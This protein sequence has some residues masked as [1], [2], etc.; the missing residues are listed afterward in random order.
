ML[1]DAEQNLDNVENYS[2]SKLT[3]HFL[4]CG[5]YNKYS[6]IQV[7]MTIL[8]NILEYAKFLLS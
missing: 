2:T 6:V 1:I 4:V 8:E 7:Y 3:A 5:V